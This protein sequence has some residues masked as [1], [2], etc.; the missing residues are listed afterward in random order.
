MPGGC[1]VHIAQ[2]RRVPLHPRHPYQRRACI[3]VDDDGNEHKMVVRKKNL[4]YH[5]QNLSSLFLLPS[6]LI[7]NLDKMTDEMIEQ[8]VLGMLFY[9]Y[10]LNIRIFD[11][12]GY[13]KKL[14]GYPRIDE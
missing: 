7:L 11:I 4:L 10:F 2:N 3:T 14:S 1:L 12:S 9:P 8:N 6:D 13:V 5:N